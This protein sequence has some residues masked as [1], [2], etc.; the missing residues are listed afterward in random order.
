MTTSGR[1]KNDIVMCFVWWPSDA[2]QDQCVVTE[3]DRETGKY[4]RDNRN[5]IMARVMAMKT[6]QRHACRHGAA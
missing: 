6:E 5:Q 1:F 3:K 2:F 4:I